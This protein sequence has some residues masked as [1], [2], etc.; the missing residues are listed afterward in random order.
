MDALGGYRELEPMQRAL[1]SLVFVGTLVITGVLERLQFQLRETETTT[2]WASNG[3]DVVNLFA[4]ATMAIGLR[5]I[6]FTGPIALCIAATLVL[7]LSALQTALEKHPHVWLWS[8]GAA[9]ALGAP[10]LIAP[11]SV[12]LAFRGAIKWLFP[13]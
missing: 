8:L 2:W 13:V 9:L 1:G 11:H 3:R 10:V 12:Q 6:G 7:L 4:L 5:V